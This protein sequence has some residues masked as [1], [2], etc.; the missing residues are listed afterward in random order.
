MRP[1]WLI[2]IPV[3]FP[4]HLGSVLHR[5]FYEVLSINSACDIILLSHL[6]YPN[7]L[8]PCPPALSQ[9]IFAIPLRLPAGP[10]AICFCKR[11]RTSPIVYFG[12]GQARLTWSRVHLGYWPGPVDGSACRVGPNYVRQSFCI[13]FKT[14]WAEFENI[15]LKLLIYK[16]LPELTG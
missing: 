4:P 2:P 3:L 8:E 6:A 7:T 12:S 1:E 9:G 5:V 16:N 13:R 15:L 10:E 14:N 11:N